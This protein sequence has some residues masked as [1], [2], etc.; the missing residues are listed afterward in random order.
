MRFC[1]HGVLQISLYGRIIKFTA[2]GVSGY[3]GIDV[4]SRSSVQNQSGKFNQN[5][6]MIIIQP[7]KLAFFDA[8]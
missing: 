7:R 6:E 2:G 3:W 1:G 8:S 5:L 4:E